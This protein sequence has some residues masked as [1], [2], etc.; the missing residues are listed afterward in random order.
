MSYEIPNLSTSGGIETIG[1]EVA[2]QV[3][4]VWS[5]ILFFVFMGIWGAG[6]FAQERKVGAGNAAMWAAISGLITTTG[7]FILFLY[8]NL[9]PLETIIISIIITIIA[10]AAFIISERN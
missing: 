10:A 1:A 8:D 4:F 2:R 9:V 6:Y 5:G 7:A 3:N